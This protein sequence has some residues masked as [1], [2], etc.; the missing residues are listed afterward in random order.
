ML[1]PESRIIIS[2]CDHSGAWS[3]PYLEAGYDVRRYDLQQ[4]QDIRL[5]KFPGQIYGLLAA[6][7]CTMFCIGANHL[8]AKRTEAQMLD[9]LSIVDACYRLAAVSNPRFWAIENSA[10]QL[11]KW[12]G[13]PAYSFQP[14][15][16]GDGYRKLTH[17]WGKFD[18]PRQVPTLTIGKSGAI[19]NA[20]S[21]AGSRMN[22][23]SI[24]PAG[25]ARAF[26]EANQ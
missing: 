17:L 13:P 4:G 9:A 25:F 7:P 23:R 24:T 12:L 5:L 2:L 21:E 18:F 22:N 6:P 8:Q 1:F 3:R 10:G 20:K 15:W 11:P 16:F 19:E 14:Y 26:F